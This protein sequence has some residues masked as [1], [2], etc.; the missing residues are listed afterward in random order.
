MQ[1]AARA[2]RTAASVICVVLLWVVQP[3]QLNPTIIAPT[4]PA[5][6]PQPPHF[7]L[8]SVFG[9]IDMSSV[10]GTL[11]APQRRATV[12]HRT[13][14]RRK[15]CRRHCGSFRPGEELPEDFLADLRPGQGNVVHRPGEGE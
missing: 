3:P 9:V 7:S 5:T 12:R 14:R 4:A 15:L 2:F 1:I 11:W 6:T 10:G 13:L 8:I